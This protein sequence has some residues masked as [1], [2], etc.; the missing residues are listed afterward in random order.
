MKT[1]GKTASTSKQRSNERIIE[2]RPI[3]AHSCH[4]RKSPAPLPPFP[5]VKFPAAPVGH[6][7]KSDQFRLIP[8]L[9]N[10][11][12]FEL[13]EPHPKD[14]KAAKR[15]RI[16]CELCGLGVRRFGRAAP[17]GLRCK[18]NNVVNSQQGQPVEAYKKK[19]SFNRVKFFFVQ[20]LHDFNESLSTDP[21][22]APPL[23][24]RRP[25]AGNRISCHRTRAII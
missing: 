24:K 21:L 18:F 5:S 16:R 23:L 13:K 8:T 22:L 25:N 2:P 6:P 20:N 10:K 7:S 4:S 19:H 1:G 3:R 11:F 9:K 17:T 14:A 15:V 12:L